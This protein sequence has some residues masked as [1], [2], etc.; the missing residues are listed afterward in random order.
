MDKPAEHSHTANTCSGNMPAKGR[1]TL[2]VVRSPMTT[3]NRSSL[4]E[5]SESKIARIV[6]RGA[7]SMLSQGWD[8]MVCLPFYDIE[9]PANT[10]KINKKTAKN[11]AM[12]IPIQIKKVSKQV[13]RPRHAENW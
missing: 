7:K 1:A 13:P 10:A 8:K 9:N 6:A 2:G 3:G 12:K 4:H 5:D 11:I